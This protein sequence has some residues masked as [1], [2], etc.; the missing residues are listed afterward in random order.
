MLDL[1]Y[2]ALVD[3][4]DDDA[5]TV[6]VLTGHGRGFCSGL[7]IRLGSELVAVLTADGRPP[8]TLAPHRAPP[9]SGLPLPSDPASF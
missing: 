2:D 7:D 4:R 5:I 8:P 9:P 1:W 3:A 6:I